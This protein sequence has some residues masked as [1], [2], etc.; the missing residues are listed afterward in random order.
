MKKN[1]SIKLKAVFLLA[2]FSLNIFVGSA[3]ALGLD[4]GFNTKVH[5]EIN[6]PATVGHIHNDGIKHV[7]REKKENHS[8]DQAHSHDEGINHHKSGNDK[9]NCCNDIIR[10]FDQ[11]DKS[12]PNSFS[13]LS[14]VFFTVFVASY[15]SINFLPHA[16][17]VTG[18]NRFVRC[19]HPPIPDIRIAIRSFQI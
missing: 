18:Q 8:H 14:P 2:V 17:I 10:S 12:V 16:N 9:D 15:Y 6:A 4:M 5:G 19:H 13:I 7:H 3:C 11:L 1:L